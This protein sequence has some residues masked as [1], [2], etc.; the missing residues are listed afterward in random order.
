MERPVVVEDNEVLRIR[1]N[2]SGLFLPQVAL[3]QPLMKG[4]I[5]GDVVDPATGEL[6]TQI[7]APRDGTIMALRDQPVISPGEMVA[8]LLCPNKEK[9]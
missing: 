5:L 8:R 9:Q 3:E 1:T 2:R 6:K 7:T 4:D